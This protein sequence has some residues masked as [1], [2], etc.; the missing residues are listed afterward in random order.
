MSFVIRYAA[1][2]CKTATNN[3]NGT[4]NVYVHYINDHIV[5]TGFHFAVDVYWRTLD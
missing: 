2:K 1:L 3:I 5:P 4:M